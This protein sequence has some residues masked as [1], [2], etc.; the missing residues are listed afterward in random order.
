MN[1]IGGKIANAWPEEHVGRLRHYQTLPNV[2]GYVARTDR[3]DESRIIG[4]PTET[5]LYAPARA[6]QD[7]G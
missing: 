7:P 2:I 6:T 4:T 3:Y 5:N 1:S